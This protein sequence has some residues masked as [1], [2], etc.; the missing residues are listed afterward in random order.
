M[1]L[2]GLDIL[3]DSETWLAGVWKGGEADVPSSDPPQG[4]G[5]DPLVLFFSL[6]EENSPEQTLKCLWP[7]LALAQSHGVRI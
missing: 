6:R 7:P 1:D 4:A 5:F 2:R 3:D